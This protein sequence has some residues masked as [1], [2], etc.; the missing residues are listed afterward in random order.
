ML[1]KKTMFARVAVIA[2][3]LGASGAALADTAPA[4]IG[5]LASSVN[6]ADVALA[7]LAVSGTLVTLYVTWKGARFVIN[8]I[9]RG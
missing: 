3:A 7:I 2:A 9:Q 5:A 8:A 4:T 6:F 1:N